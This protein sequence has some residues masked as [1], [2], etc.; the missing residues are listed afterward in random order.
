RKNARINRWSHFGPLSAHG[1]MASA[2]SVLIS[3]CALLFVALS[4]LPVFAQASGSVAWEEWRSSGAGV[5]AVENSWSA[6]APD[7]TRRGSVLVTRRDAGLHSEGKAIEVHR[8][9]AVKT[10]MAVREKTVAV[11]MWRGA[12]QPFVKVALV[13]LAADAALDHAPVRLLD[14]Q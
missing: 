2:R 13:D 5:V 12:P 11:V 6:P 8:G 4:A 14:L 10:A 9:P 7:G 1:G 3:L